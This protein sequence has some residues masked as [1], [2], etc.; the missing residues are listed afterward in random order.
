M[1]KRTKT[2]VIKDSVKK[3]WNFL[4]IPFY[5]ACQFNGFSLPS[6][7]HCVLPHI[8][9]C[10]ISFLLYSASIEEKTTTGA[11]SDQKKR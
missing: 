8:Q 5:F 11:K 1:Y 3:S 9:V 2:Y 6:P 4:R 10:F 7:W